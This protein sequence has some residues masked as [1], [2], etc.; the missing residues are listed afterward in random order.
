MTEK[1]IDIQEGG[2]YKYNNSIIQAVFAGM[3]PYRCKH[4]CFNRKKIDYCYKMACRA[5]EREDGRNVYFIN[6][7]AIKGKEW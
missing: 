3:Q 1:L 2:T 5:D 6:Y 4:C 7:Y